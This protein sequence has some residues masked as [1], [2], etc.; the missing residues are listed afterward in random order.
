MGAFN[1]K[2]RP[3]TPPPRGTTDETDQG[4]FTGPAGAPRAHQLLR[5]RSP[6]FH[7]W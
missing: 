2:S 3:C 1:N 5:E 4:H 7:D 6:V